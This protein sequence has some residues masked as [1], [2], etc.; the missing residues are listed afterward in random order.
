MKGCCFGSFKFYKFDVFY[1]FDV[2]VIVV[3][4]GVIEVVM[5]ILLM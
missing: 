5:W 1:E 4:Y 2:G 3:S